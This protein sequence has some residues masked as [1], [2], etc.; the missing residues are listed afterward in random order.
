MSLIS[1][2][3]LLCPLSVDAKAHTEGNWKAHPPI[4][5]TKAAMTSPSGY[6]PQQIRRAY[7]FDQVTA[8]GNGQIIGIV[9]AFDAPT[10]GKDLQTFIQTFHVASM[11][12]LPGAPA[13]TVAS[14]PH[15]CFQK[16]FAGAKP[17]ADPGWSL[18]TSLDV[19]WAH[20]AAPG[21]DILLV[22]SKN[23][24]I[25]ALM[26][27]VDAAVSNGASIVSMSWGGPE[28]PTELKY[29]AHFRK[30]GVS[31]LASSGDNGTG[32][33]YPASSPFVLSVGGTTLMLD[34][35]GAM[36]KKERGWQGS[37]GGVSAYEA[38]PG[39]QSSLSIAASGMRTG[40]DVAYDADPAT[41]VSV[42]DSTPFQK[43]AGWYSIGGTSAASPQWAGIVAIANE[44]RAQ[45]LSTAPIDHAFAYDA[46]L[47]KGNYRDIKSGSNGTCGANCKAS[48]GYDLVTGLGSP[49]VNV[50]VPVLAGH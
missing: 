14:G 42:Y 19:Q 32:E 45:S 21:A 34:A 11:N 39:Y 16:I 13:C 26:S 7:G 4:H 6:S 23:A 46:A 20:V 25:T 44:K 17:K 3:V 27:N 12:G 29:D 48:A 37:G 41:G 1:M 40:P 38:Q 18:E 24:G 15:P 35:N 5:I 36:T 10:I 30:D 33:S 28:F 47:V 31:F 9:D 2:L 8:S 49:I 22:E 50:L 43:K